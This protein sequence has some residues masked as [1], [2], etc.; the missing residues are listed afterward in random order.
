MWVV[1]F[2]G[3]QGSVLVVGFFGSS[4]LRSCGGV[5]RAGACVLEILFVGL[6]W[7]LF[8]FGVLEGCFF[9]VGF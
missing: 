4:C 6:G 2:L 5:E 3:A 1:L 9:V 8:W 7:F